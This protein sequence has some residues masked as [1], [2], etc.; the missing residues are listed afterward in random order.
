MITGDNPMT[1]AAI[2]AE[3]GVMILAEATPE[4]KLDLIKDYQPG[5]S[6]AM[7]SITTPRH[8]PRRM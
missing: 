2:V 5:L 1:A 6:V 8:L 7:T 4:T 3:A